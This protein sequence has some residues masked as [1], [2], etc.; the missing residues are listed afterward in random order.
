MKT[1]RKTEEKER[2]RDRDGGRETRREE[3]RKR[4]GDAWNL[5]GEK[6]HIVDDDV[7]VAC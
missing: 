6:S 5:R 7:D 1:K 2:M 4:Q 3:E